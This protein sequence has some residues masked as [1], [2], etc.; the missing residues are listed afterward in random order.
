MKTEIIDYYEDDF[1][2][3][4]EE[5]RDYDYSCANSTDIEMQLDGQIIDNREEYHPTTLKNKL[6][7]T[8]KTGQPEKLD[9]HNSDLF[10]LKKQ[11]LEQQYHHAS[12]EHEQ[13]MEHARLEH[14][15]RIS[16]S[17]EEHKLKIRILEAELESKKFLGRMNKR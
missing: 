4:A 5:P 16:Q 6:L 1:E 15:Q 2:E 14:V 17:E 13:K 9:P 12:L 3:C 11:I 8:T 10:N 7:D